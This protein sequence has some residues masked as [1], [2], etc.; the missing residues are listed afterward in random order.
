MVQEEAIKISGITGDNQIYPLTPAQKQTKRTYIDGFGRPI[1][2]VALAASPAGKDIV[3]YATY[4][5]VGANGPQTTKYLPYVGIDGAGEYH[6]SASSEQTAFYSNGLRDKVV[7]DADPWTQSLSEASPL[8]RP[9]YEGTAG[10]GFQPVPGSGTQHFK[11][12]TERTNNSSAYVNDGYNTGIR[13]WN[14]DGTSSGVYPTGSLSVTEVKDESGNVTD[15][16][17]NIAGKVVL[18]RQ[19]ITGQVI[20]GTTEYCLDSYYIYDNAN[21]LVAMVPPKALTAIRNA[22]GSPWNISAASTLVFQYVYDN[23]GRVIQKLVPS[24]GW[25][26]Y[27]YDPMNR[28]VLT[29]DANLRSLHK[30]TYFKYDSKG[31]IAGK[32]IYIDAV[33]T[34]QAGMTAFVSG[35]SYGVFYYEDRA[36]GTTF[37]NC[38]TNRVFPVV[39]YDQS[40]LQDLEYIFY[41][42]YDLAESGN[43]T[44]YYVQ[45]LAGEETP[46]MLARGIETIVNK[47]T[48]NNDGT[49]SVW[50]QYVYYYDKRGHLIQVKGH[51][52]TY[53]SGYGDIKTI[54]PDFIGKPLIVKTSKTINT[55]SFYTTLT[56]SYDNSNRLLT[57]DESI[58]GAAAVRVGQY[59]YN[60]LGQLVNKKLHSTDDVN[61]LQNV[62]FRYN[63]HGALTSINNSTLAVDTTNFTNSDA[64]DLFGEEILYEKTDA[65][66]GNT[67]YYNGNISAV[68]WDANATTNKQR[69][70]VYAY[71]QLNRLTSGHYQDRNYQSTGAW[72]DA[73]INDETGITYDINGNIEKLSRYSSGTL[74]D[75]LSYSYSGN[76]LSN[77]SDASNVTAGFNG[78]TT[79]A[80]SFDNSGNLS[81]DPKKGVTITYNVFNKTDKITFTATGNYIR[82][83][84]DADAILVRKETYVASTAT[85]TTYDYI[86]GVVGQNLVLS[87]FAMP[88]GRVRYAGSAYTFEYFIRDHLGNV[89]V[90]FDGTGASAIAKQENSYYPFGMTLPGNTVSSAPNTHLFNGGSDWQND[91]ANNPDL[92]ETLNRNYDPELGR[93]ISVD[94][95]A[96]AS[97]SMTTYHFAGNN[98]ISFSDPSGA[99]DMPPGL[100]GSARQAIDQNNASELA[101]DAYFS[102]GI[103]PNEDGDYD[104]VG[105]GQL[106]SNGDFGASGAG[107]AARTASYDQMLGD[108]G[109]DASTDVGLSTINGN[110]STWKIQYVSMLQDAFGNM[111]PGVTSATF[112][113]FSTGNADALTHDQELAK[114]GVITSGTNIIG[115]L[116]LG[117]SGGAIEYGTV[118]TKKGW[119]QDYYTVY[120]VVTTATISGSYGGFLIF[121]K[122]GYQNTFSDW[123][124]PVYEIAGSV[125]VVGGSYGWSSTYYTAAVGVGPSVS[126]PQIGTAIGMV[127]TT[128]LIGSPYQ[129]PV[130][131]QSGTWGPL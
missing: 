44:Q 38:Y 124:G 105:G 109:I 36:P 49:L 99:L 55:T 31:R 81:I 102:L 13:M 65:L 100:P 17:K 118:G 58:N 117:T 129:P 120:H 9:L 84:Y 25:V 15:F 61:F 68:K 20:D 59:I 33:N 112:N 72:G 30:W 54:V 3:G 116:G 85:T 90:S 23:L 53:A 111:S 94:P 119:Y 34:T 63:I 130:A 47:K 1:Q 92:Y 16:Y 74:I 40:A 103:V 77:V 115:T 32:G 62:D 10:N 51:N 50:T 88:E 48:I 45:G 108:L 71:D 131:T 29:Q 95:M 127:G 106:G 19:I 101:A 82:Y 86:D 107:K 26:Y 126:L 37:T 96:E 125:S 113:G 56:P 27:V 43:P 89:R 123:A 98:P 11:T 35:Q 8:G 24:S 76:Q 22:N 80:Y 28:L 52:Q 57:L 18:K 66:I 6:A 64:N 5:I 41:D 73:G 4:N 83:T 39:N 60:E 114:Y 78:T 21:E 46:S 2:Q 79:T 104:W 128:Y 110:P 87:Y 91:F 70:F 14:Y 75:N 7:D 93:F 67:A 97:E 12:V 121:G 42:D 69:S 122:N